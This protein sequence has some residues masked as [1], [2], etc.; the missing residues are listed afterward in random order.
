MT[1]YVLDTDIMGFAFQRHPTVLQRLQ[2]LPEDDLVVTTI[3][4]PLWRGSRWLVACRRAH[5][6]V[7]R[8]RAYARLHRG[9]NFYQQWV[10]LPFD[11]AAA[12]I[13][14]QLR[15]QKLRLGT[16]DLAIAAIT[17]AVRG[18]LVTRNTVDF[19]RIPGLVLEDWARS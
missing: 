18:I 8:A 17:L 4:Y 7:T 19:Q 6:G 15:T 10:C 16:N 5:D 1:L 12:A 13:F 9:L 11:E 3:I 2:H 14:D